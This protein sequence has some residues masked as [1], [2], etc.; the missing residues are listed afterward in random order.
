MAQPDVPEST[1]DEADRIFLASL[2][3]K[4]GFATGFIAVVA[5]V[6]GDGSESTV[7]YNQL[8]LNLVTVLG[9]LEFAKARI[10]LGMLGEGGGPDDLDD[11]LDDD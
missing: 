4:D 11:D 6:N 5:V 10:L 3:P 9:A 8:S 2:T 1:M 7:V